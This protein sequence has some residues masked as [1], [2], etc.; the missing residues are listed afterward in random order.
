MEIPNSEEEEPL[1]AYE[2]EIMKRKRYLTVWTYVK[3]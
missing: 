3:F 1:D 2:E